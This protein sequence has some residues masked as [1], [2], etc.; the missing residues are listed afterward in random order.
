MRCSD[1]KRKDRVDNPKGKDS[2]DDTRFTIGVTP[3]DHCFS[4][5]SK[6]IGNPPASTM[7]DI[8]CRFPDALPAKKQKTG[9]HPV[10]TMV[11]VRT[12]LPCYF[13]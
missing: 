11:S 7:T 1:Q 2:K 9:I 13:L 5:G 4:R 3:E 12:R 8:R 10:R 6:H